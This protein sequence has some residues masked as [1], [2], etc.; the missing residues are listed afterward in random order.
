MEYFA[1]AQA[2]RTRPIL[3][4]EGPGDEASTW[5]AGWRKLHASTTL[6][7][8]SHV[9]PVQYYWFTVAQILGEISQDSSALSMKPS[10]PCSMNGKQRTLLEIQ[11]SASLKVE[12]ED[13]VSD[14]R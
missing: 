13:E 1:H 7:S 5:V 10:K 9:T 6:F 12:V 3:R 8:L 11:Y 2:V 4:L 14:S